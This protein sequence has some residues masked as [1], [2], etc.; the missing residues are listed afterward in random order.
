[1]TLAMNCSLALFLDGFRTEYHRTVG[2][3]PHPVRL[4]TARQS[5]ER[6][7]EAGSPSAESWYHAGRQDAING[8]GA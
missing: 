5:F 2:C 4:A 8:E 3:A 6:L 1:M 7:Y